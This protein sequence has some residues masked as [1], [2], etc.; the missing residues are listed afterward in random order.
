MA[1]RIPARGRDVAEAI[2]Q[3]APW[4]DYLTAYA[5]EILFAR[6][7]EAGRREMMRLVQTS[8]H[9]TVPESMVENVL[10][11]RE[12]FEDAAGKELVAQLATKLAGAKVK[13]FKNPEL[14]GEFLQRYAPGTLPSA[15]VLRGHDGDESRLL[16]HGASGFTM[17]IPGRPWL[18]SGEVAPRNSTR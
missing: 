16:V 12:R 8:Q 4:D 17:V 18:D 15:F 14:T 10:S 1:R 7:P 3:R 13:S 2:L 9:P 5:L 11:D 6:D